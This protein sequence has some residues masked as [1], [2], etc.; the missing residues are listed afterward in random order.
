MVCF[1]NDSARLKREYND[2]EDS[3]KGLYDLLTDLAKFCKDSYNKDVVLTMILRT[4]EEQDNI[5]KGTKNS[6]GVKYDD[7]PWKSPHQFSHALDIR[8]KTYTKNEIKAIEE[9]LNDKYNSKNFYK[10]TALCHDVGQGDHF[11]IQFVEG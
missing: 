4:K 5:Y 3:N 10:W 2:L 6:K 8:S 1:K 9:Y 11:H 7:K